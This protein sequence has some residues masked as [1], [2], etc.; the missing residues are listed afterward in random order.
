M[1]VTYDVIFYVETRTVVVKT[2][3]QET[4]VMLIMT[5]AVV[6]SLYSTSTARTTVAGDND[7][8]CFVDGG[9]DNRARPNNGTR[10][11]LAV[12]FRRRRCV[13]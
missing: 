5:M 12:Q 9:V 11:D 8:L 1:S 2:K 10:R 3:C 13:G 7:S 6:V 4:L